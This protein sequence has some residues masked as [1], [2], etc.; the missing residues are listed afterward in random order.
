MLENDNQKAF[1]F[2]GSAGEY[3]GIW[4]VNILLTILT[5]GIYTAWAKVRSNRYF[6]GHTIVAGSN[7][8]YLA[9][10]IT[11]LKGYLIAVVIFIIYSA[12][13]YFAPGFE[14]IFF[15]LLMIALPF[16]IVRAMAFRLRN[17]AYR[18]LRFRFDRQYGQAARIYLGIGI[19]I[20]LTL[21]LILPYF[22]Y[23]A[24][25]FL[26]GN[27]SYGKSRFSLQCGAGDFYKIYLFAIGILIGAGVI[28]TIVMI[29][30]LTEITRIMEQA[31]QSG[32]EPDQAAIAAAMTGLPMIMSLLMSLL[33]FGLF[34]YIRTAIANL[35]WNNI[36]IDGGHKFSSCLTIGRMA[37]IIFSNLLAIALS[38]GL[39]IPWCKVRM[40][41][42]RMDTLS[43]I[44]EGDL[45][46][47][48]AEKTEEA[49]ALGEEMGDVF[50]LDIGAIG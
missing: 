10:P 40:V 29:P 42:Y 50:D 33:Y 16:I 49:S 44:P 38:F 5:L 37:W 14:I 24:N 45:D 34:I 46:K 32:G 13:S 36:S 3:F 28:V 30:A 20:P 11:I 17:S 31:T 39:L 12:I 27:A 1:S 2:T 15:L 6:Y 4:I 26:I 47:F 41:R 22:A 19:L 18:N 43:L 35:V 9:S 21:G 23:R 8:D 25:N 48:I 7:F